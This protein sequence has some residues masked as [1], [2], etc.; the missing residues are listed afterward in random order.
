MS[1]SVPH[2]I[3]TLDQYQSSG[4]RLSDWYWS[5]GL[6]YDVIQILSYMYVLFYYV[7]IIANT[8]NVIIHKYE[9]RECFCLQFDCC[10]V[11]NYMDFMNA[12][13]WNK[14]YNGQTLKTPLSCCKGIE[15]E[16]PDIKYPADTTCA[17]NP[18]DANSNWENVRNRESW[19]LNQ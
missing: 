19:F 2:P 1:K 8:H 3:S 15:G 6:I 4:L 7:F 18:I 17:T 5:L 13:H 9:K 10:G 14:T 12:T 11:D 16:F